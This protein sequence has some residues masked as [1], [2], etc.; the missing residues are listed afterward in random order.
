MSTRRSIAATVIGVSLV[1]TVILATHEGR[2]AQQPDSDLKEALLPGWPANQ[3]KSW[4]FQLPSDL[5]TRDGISLHI[6]GKPST[7]PPGANITFTSPPP[8]IRASDAEH[9]VMAGTVLPNIS[10]LPHPTSGTVTIQ[11]LDL[12]KIGAMSTTPGQDLRVLATLGIGDAKATSSVDLS[13][14]A[15][16]LPAGRF[17]GEQPSHEGHWRDNE[18]YLMTFYVQNDR[19]VWQYDVVVHR[20]RVKV[21]NATN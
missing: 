8:T 11:L 1:A 20:E 18:L 3:T 12:S 7:L 14:E 4:T 6:R 13:P 16:V 17:V 9:E 10:P 5:Q 2:T 15:T 21:A 19:T